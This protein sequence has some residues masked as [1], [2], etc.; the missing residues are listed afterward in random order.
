MCFWNALWGKHTTILMHLCQAIET[1]PN[2]RVR[3][4]A[5]L[6]SP[7]TLL[8][9]DRS[10][11]PEVP[12]IG[13]ML[14]LLQVEVANAVED[15]E[16]AAKA[17]EALMS[18]IDTID[19]EEVR[20][21]SASISI[22]KVLLA[23]H[24]NLS[25][26]VQLDWALRLRVV[27][28]NIV[29]MNNPALG[30][31]T[32]WLRT[33]FPPGVD[34]PGF[35]FAVIVTRIRSSA[36]MLA[37]IEALNALNENDR[38]NFLDAAGISL[39]MG[40]VAFVHNG[41]AQEQLDNLDLRPA[42]ERFE[43]MSD[44]AQH[45]AR[46]DFQAELANARSIILD[47]GLNDQPAALVVVDIAIREIGS[48][49]ALVRQKAKVLSHSGDDLAA[50]RLLVSVEDSVGVDSPIDRVLALRDGAVSAARAKLF[51]DALRLFGKAHEVLIT[52]GQHPGLAV[53]MQV[54]S[55]LV[56]WDMNDRPR[57]I[58]TLADALDAVELLDPAASRQN[59]RAHQFARAAIGLFWHRLDPYPSGPARHIAIGQASA[60][61]G[62]E[63][64][65]GIDL[66]PLAYNWRILALCEIELG[67]EV[68][69]ERRS[70]AKQNGPG[71][72]SIE[73]F[74]A[75]ARYAHAVTSGSDVT[76]A[77]RLG[78]LA[79]GAYRTTKRLRDGEGEADQASPS[80]VQV[81][82]VL[83]QEGLSDIVKTIPVDLL[84]WQRFRSTWDAEFVTRI[85]AACVATWGDVAAI[86]DIIGAAS[87]GAVSGT[88]STSVALAARLAA[89]PDL[90][91]NPRARFDRD[92]LLVSHTAHSLARR[93]IEPVV[94]SIVAE[95]WSTVLKDETFALR[96]PMQHTPDIEVALSDMNSHGLKAAACLLLA[97]APAVS[98]PLSQSWEQ[99]LRQISG[100]RSINP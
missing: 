80:Q 53:S 8:R 85:E 64:L 54:E 92:L 73:M 78:L 59:E 49:P 20:L 26:A 87:S 97:A 77:F 65:L 94:V 74:I 71:L 70:L 47:E 9:T 45:W 72:A 82:Q 76:E 5:A 57:A 21:L 17:A 51:S 38:N 69:I 24:I 1:L 22:P 90:R 42:L 60:L 91:G 89:M 11:Y 88:P 46:P 28:Q 48:A 29:A 84:I 31:A 67:V 66:K 6:L 36:R 33:G 34:L 99:L 63:A 7:M 100:S 18:E 13:A 16:T 32:Q 41:W 23:D 27:L 86:A 25:P 3:G 98:V 43:R 93:V 96:S 37:M 10:I 62:D 83:L 35:L 19:H 12:P 58:L 95:G 55:A 2:E 44:I 39:G 79:M 4:A 61:T 81:L 30:S 50:A 68:G 52:E 40:A 56:S 14:R 75:M 15:D